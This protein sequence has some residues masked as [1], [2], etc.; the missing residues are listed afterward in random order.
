M[1]FFARSIA[2][3][4]KVERIRYTGFEKSIMRNQIVKKGQRPAKNPQRPT[5]MLGKMKGPRFFLKKEMT[6]FYKPKT[7]LETFKLKPY[8]ARPK[9]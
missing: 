5:P 6:P 2:L 1:K 3:F 7:N 9:E 4:E 8:I